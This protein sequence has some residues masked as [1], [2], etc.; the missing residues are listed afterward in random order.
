MMVGLTEET[1]KLD[2][3]R[4]GNFNYIGSVLTENGKNKEQ[5]SKLK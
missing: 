2:I 5:K 1:Q 3:K 4:V